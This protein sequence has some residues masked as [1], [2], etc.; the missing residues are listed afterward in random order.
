MKTAGSIPSHLKDLNHAQKKAV[1]HV[2]GPL[3]VIAG[4]GTGKTA[5]ITRHITHQIT[6][7]NVKPQ[8]ILA[9]TFTEKAAV[10]MEERVDMMTPYGFNDVSINTFHAFGDQILRRHSLEIGLPAYVT[11][12]NLSESMVF[13]CDHL[14]EFPLSLYRPLGNPMRYAEAILTLFS[15]LKDED[16]SHQEYMMYAEKL[17]KKSHKEP[18]NNE[19]VLYAAQQME[20][21]QTYKKYEELKTAHGYIDF[22]DQVALA[23]RILRTRP[24]ICA[25]YQDTFKLILV[26]EFQDTNY[27]Q[28][29]LL[30]CLAARARSLMVV[31]DDDQA[32]FKF[33]GACLS[34]IINF[35]KTYPSASYI[36]FTENYRSTQTILNTAYRLI[37]YNDPDRLEAR[38]GI[39]KKLI[40]QIPYGPAVQHVSLFNLSKEADWV[41]DKIAEFLTRENYTF[42]DCAILVRTNR[43]AKAF[44]LALQFRGIPWYFSGNTGL[45]T[46]EEIRL[47]LSFLRVMADPADSP[48]LYY[49]SNSSLYTIN[50][51]DIAL[52]N[53]AAQNKSRSLWYMYTHEELFDAIGITRLS[54]K[55]IKRLIKDLHHYL[56]LTKELSAGKLLYVFL[57]ENGILRSIAKAETIN[58]ELKAKNIAKFFSIIRKFEEI[59]Q[60]D[61]VA[62][63]VKFID[64]LIEAGDDPATAEAEI[65][66]D[67][68]NVLTVHK[69]KGLEFKAV[70]MVCLV[71]GRFP[72]R[73]MGESIRMPDELVK[74]IVFE[75]DYHIHEERRLFYVGITRAKEYLFF[76]SAQDY[77]GKRVPKP[78]RF[79]MEALD[80]PKRKTGPVQQKPYQ[81]IELFAPPTQSPDSLA[82]E[83]IADNEVVSLSPYA[84]DDY[85][86]CPLKYKYIHIIGIPLLR[87][88]T[89]VYG[90]ALHEALRVLHTAIMQKK[91]IGIENIISA[92]EAHWISEGFISRE[93]EEQRKKAGRKA[94]EEYF[95]YTKEL[96][97]T[98]LGVEEKF[99]FV[100]GNNRISGR[101]DLSCEDHGKVSIIDFK[102]T[103]VHRQKDADSK[104]RSSRQLCIYALGYESKYK[105]LPDSLQ[106]FFL[107]SGLIGSTEPDE[108]KINK[109]QEEIK[110]A[111][112]GL[113]RREFTA[114]PEYRVCTYCPF[115]DI[116]SEARL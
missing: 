91:H 40:A 85:L 42:R 26:D 25:Q 87:N 79:I 4:A 67:A 116:C 46:R 30:R 75:G 14:F 80:I 6:T 7:H 78:S 72:A 94:L 104:A 13:F 58:D 69:A 48:S 73:N 11:V 99:K 36:V 10:E 114:T 59:A 19:T 35:R 82:L 103:E 51:A 31:G 96:P 43:H 22:G 9:L 37:R 88:H 47:L 97:Q 18:N 38:E 52:L 70:F 29:E 53:A 102:G 93:H 23:L 33:R 84:I 3:L 101:W 34:N 60:Y 110:L 74:D 63:F 90:S 100:T 98:I 57:K 115:Q 77:G 113:R 83:P 64:S 108:K 8:E 1:E 107:G 2:H 39:D 32:I 95:V 21:A 49:L 20:L 112:Q 28:F 55:E 50:P 56:A 92:F 24:S 105:K 12:L 62:H 68:V 41:A 54:H 44:L 111:A 106:L 5:S 17:N 66:F 71:E 45:Y 76:T 16:V 65:D 15:R 109:V 61:R 81:Q 27:A 89:I 86:T